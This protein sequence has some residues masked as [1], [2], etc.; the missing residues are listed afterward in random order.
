M[1]GAL[2]GEIRTALETKKQCVKLRSVV[3]CV[4]VVLVGVYLFICL[5]VLA[6]RCNV[7]I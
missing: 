7:E 4:P 6:L 5:F 2:W 3:D 1:C